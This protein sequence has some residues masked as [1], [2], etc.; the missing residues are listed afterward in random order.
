M[1]VVGGRAI[2]GVGAIGRAAWIGLVMLKEEQRPNCSVGAAG[3]RTWTRRE[4][5][6]GR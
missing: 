3:A 4:R 2:G 5:Y 6:H 1:G